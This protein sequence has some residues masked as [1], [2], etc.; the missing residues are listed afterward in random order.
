MFQAHGLR[1]GFEELEENAAEIL[2]P[3]VQ[4][5]RRHVERQG[6]FEASEFVRHPLQIYCPLDSKTAEI[7]TWW[8]SLTVEAWASLLDSSPTGESMGRLNA[9]ISLLKSFPR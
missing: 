4:A 8:R 9:R 1:K 7:P 6:I 5:F 2:L 3:H